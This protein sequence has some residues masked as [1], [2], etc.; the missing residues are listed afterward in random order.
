MMRYRQLICIFAEG[1]RM[2]DAEEPEQCS[3]ARD[4]DAV[5]LEIAF[6]VEDV[7]NARRRAQ[8][9]KG[10]PVGPVAQ[11]SLKRIVRTLC[12]PPKGS[13]FMSPIRSGRKGKRL[14]RS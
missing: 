14:C 2:L 7:I 8:R 4:P 3:I 11:S 12:A 9:V 6:A 10:K 13:A 1:F 5:N